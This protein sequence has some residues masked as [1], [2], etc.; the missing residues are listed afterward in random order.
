[1]ENNVMVIDGSV[2]DLNK[3][4]A[5]EL[6]ELL[7]KSKARE[8]EIRKRLDKVLGIDKILEDNNER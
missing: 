4:S 8:K 1:M 5:E 2:V 6:K 7:N 3:L